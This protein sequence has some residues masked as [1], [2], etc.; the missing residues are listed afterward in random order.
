MLKVSNEGLIM[1]TT[2]SKVVTF[3]FILVIPALLTQSIPDEND[4]H[5]NPRDCIEDNFNDCCEE[6][7]DVWFDNDGDGLGDSGN[8]ALACSYYFG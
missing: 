3:I 7:F 2:Y 4:Q 8:Q 1:N 5:N 6:P